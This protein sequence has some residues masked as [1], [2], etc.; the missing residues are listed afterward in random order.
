MQA[1]PAPIAPGGLAAP[2]LS[3]SL[4]KTHVETAKTLSFWLIAILAGTIVVHYVC[5]MILILLRREY[6]VSILEDVLHV[7]LPVLSGLAGAAVT[8]YFTRDRS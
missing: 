6:G 7:W 5:V 4:K 8:Y 3:D 1:S 2:T